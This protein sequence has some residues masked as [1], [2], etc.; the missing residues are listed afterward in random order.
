MIQTGERS[1]NYTRNKMEL[2]LLE[3]GQ[4]VYLNHGISKHCIVIG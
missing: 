3:M 4:R 2:D 1:I